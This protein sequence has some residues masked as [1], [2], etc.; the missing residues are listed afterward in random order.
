[1]PMVQAYAQE[2]LNQK[3]SQNEAPDASY[4]SNALYTATQRLMSALD[5]LDH[6]VHARA[7]EQA[8]LVQQQEQAAF[9]AR[10]NENLKRERENL[11]VTIDKL[12]HE[13]KD[14]QKAASTIYKKLNDSIKRLT[15]IIGD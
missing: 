10:E 9:Y 2:L 6:N 5:R 3:E 15:N 13:Y 12:E 7:R 14:L 1:M 11:N 8:K 4:A